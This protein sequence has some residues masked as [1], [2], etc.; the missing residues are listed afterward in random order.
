[1]KRQHS[2]INIFVF[3]IM[4]LIGGFGTAS[5][6][7]AKDE[8]PLIERLA[9]DK[10]V[11]SNTVTEQSEKDVEQVKQRVAEAEIEA[12]T[13][14]KEAEIQ[15][16]AVEVEKKKAEVKLKEA[17]LAK[18][19]V[20]VARETAKDGEEIEEA[21]ETASQKEKEATVAQERLAIAEAKMLTAQEKAKVAEDEL[22]IALERTAIAE[23]KIGKPRNGVYTKLFQTGLIVLCGYLTIFVLVHVINR[24]IKDLKLRHS[25]RKYV[26]YFLNILIV[27]YVVFLWVQNISSITIFLSVISCCQTGEYYVAGL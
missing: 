1:V 3:L 8:S 10:I 19:E 18:R 22:K 2:T 16:R 26:V 24:G 12:Q 25:V 13:A 20:D 7:R 5:G 11:D 9:Q 15:A 17:E 6:V 14:K 23:G 21:V 4:G 27:L